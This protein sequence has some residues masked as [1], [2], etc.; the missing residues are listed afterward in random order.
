MSWV[1]LSQPRSPP[2]HEDDPEGPLP[3]ISTFLQ[4]IH[5][6]ATAPASRCSRMIRA[7]MRMTTMMQLNIC[8]IALL[9]VLQCTD[10]VLSRVPFLFLVLM[11]IYVSWNDDEDGGERN[12]VVEGPL[13]LLGHEGR[14]ARSDLEIHMGPRAGSRARTVSLNT[15]FIPFFAG[16]T[17]RS[18]NTDSPW[19]WPRSDSLGWRARPSRRGRRAGRTSSRGLCGARRTRVPAQCV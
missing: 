10:W 8:L 15:P 17:S 6:P 18:N 7:L 11:G 1:Q 4:Q 14:R 12:E 3:I 9:Y 2:G 5:A 16:Q 13:A 19:I